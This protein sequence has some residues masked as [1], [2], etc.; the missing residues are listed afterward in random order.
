MSKIEILVIGRNPEILQTIIRLINNTP[1]WNAIGVLTDE[2]A[3]SSFNAH[4]FKLVLFG[5][6]INKASENK[7]RLAFKT[8]NPNIIMVQHYGGGSGL[9]SAEI[10]QALGL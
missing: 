8:M 1:D 3:I 5:G 4:S 10:Y 9:L 7:L 2:E 6:G